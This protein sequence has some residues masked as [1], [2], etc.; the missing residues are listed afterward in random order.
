M[1]GRTIPSTRPV[2]QKAWRRKHAPAFSTSAD[3]EPA[4]VELRGNKLAF[5]GALRGGAIDFA[6]RQTDEAA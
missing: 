4:A 2:C 1:A 3:R 5:R 6:I